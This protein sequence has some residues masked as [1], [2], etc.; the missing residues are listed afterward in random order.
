MAPTSNPVVAIT[1]K[2]TA[3]SVQLLGAYKPRSRRYKPGVES[4]WLPSASMPASA[5]VRRASGAHHDGRQAAGARQHPP[6][7]A[8]Q[9]SAQDD[10]L[11]AGDDRAEG[12][13]IPNRSG[14]TSDGNGDFHTERRA[15][16]G[17]HDPQL[18]E[19][20]TTAERER[21]HEREPGAEHRA[22]HPGQERGAFQV[23]VVEVA[24]RPGR[25]AAEGTARGGAGRARRHPLHLR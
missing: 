16:G 13:G 12:D 11:P 5:D 18:A 8:R 10:P 14:D 25:Q 22:V 6:R 23:R 15:A 1:A 7:G 2:P 21:L 24:E 19:R 9:A 3:T 17:G 4:G 20:Q